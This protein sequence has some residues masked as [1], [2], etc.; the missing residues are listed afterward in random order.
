MAVQASTEEAEVIDRAFIVLF[1]DA[2]SFTDDFLSQVQNA[3]GSKAAMRRNLHGSLLNAVSIQLEDD[4]E[5]D[6]EDKIAELPGVVSV[7][8]IHRHPLPPKVDVNPTF[9]NYSELMKRQKPLDGGILSSHIM[10]QVDQL[11][12][13]GYTGKGSRVAI[14]DA[15]VDYTHP[16]LGGCFGEGCLVSF[17]K[18][19][20]EDVDVGNPDPSCKGHATALAGVIAAQENPLGFTGV[21][22]GVELGSYAISGCTI[23][24][25][26]EKLLAAMQQAIDDNVDILCYSMGFGNGWSSH[27][28]NIAMDAIVEQGVFLAVAAGNDGGTGI[29]HSISPADAFNNFGTGSVDNS[30]DTTLANLTSYTVDD[31]SN[32]T[33]FAWRDGEAG[34]PNT[35]GWGDIALPLWANLNNAGKGCDELP[36][37]TPDLSDKIL[38]VRRLDGCNAD[39]QI[40]GQAGKKNAKYVIISAHQDDGTI[41]V[42][43]V[44]ESSISALAMVSK[45]VGAEWIELLQAGSTI[46]VN[47]STADALQEPLYNDAYRGGRMSS[48]SQWGPSFDGY[49]TTTASAPGANILTTAPVGSTGGLYTISGGTSLAG[50][51]VGAVAALVNE[52][53]GKTGWKAL[54]SLLAT[55]ARPLVRQTNSDSWDDPSNALASVAQQGGGLIQAYDAAF[56]PCVLSVDG[57]NF[58]DTDNRE[59]LSFTIMNESPNDITY[60]LNNIPAGTVY[61]FNDASL[62]SPA[63][64]DEITNNLYLDQITDLSFSTGSSVSVPGNGGSATVE[65]TAL[66]DPLFVDSTRLPIWSGFVALNG[67]DGFNYTIPYLGIAG[68]LSDTPAIY[69]L[70]WRLTDPNAGEGEEPRPEIPEGRVVQLPDEQPILQINIG[71]GLRKVVWDV[72]DTASGEKLGQADIWEITSATRTNL[73]ITWDGKFKDG[74]RVPAGKI[75]VVA[76]MLKTFG[77]EDNDEDWL[78]LESAAMEITW[79]DE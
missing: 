69:D 26:D 53:R 3:T 29:F 79:T 21:A 6:A 39:T 1:Q 28:L 74:T 78:S 13:L 32:V 31:N 48:F 24:G 70:I 47:M 9:G 8:P 19:W 66:G 2:Q 33:N 14:I 4:V 40:A 25:D 65:V 5:E 51:F 12:E 20:L 18:E 61:S 60:E 43:R 23:G 11:K 57:L 49:I 62:G 45:Q 63:T 41:E 67:S 15:W 22:P 52:V 44:S 27:T 77:Y 73:L 59:V 17:G 46:M 71:M 54:Q 10:A 30:M 58:N 16:A 75:A 7:D 68:S 72:L 50:P 55:T 35:V 56:A 64:Y 34:E 76:R 42:P 36:D 38:L 37:D